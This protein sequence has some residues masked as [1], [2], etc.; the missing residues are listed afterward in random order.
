MK[1]ILVLLI[2]LMLVVTAGLAMAK[3]GKDKCATIKDGTITYGR[4]GNPSTE[5]LLIGFDEWGYNYQGRFF[6]GYYC[7]SYRDA[8]W[9]QPYKDIKLMMKWSDEWLSNKDCNGDGKLDRGYSC[10]PE[11]ASS[12]AC[13]GAWLTN[14]QFWS[15]E[16]E[17]GKT[18]KWNYFVKIVMVPKD[19]Y[20]EGDMWYT[21]D[22]TKI[23]EV[24]WGAYAIIQ[25]VE[26]DPCAGLHGL[27]YL[28][29]ASAGLGYYK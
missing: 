23:G 25:Q 19:A 27:Q 18:C 5:I 10:N 11:S 16:G 29:P 15:Y 12:S 20:K 28:S 14:H 26:N 21:A 24:I 2:G 4:V 13:Q 1:K 8:A 6:N 3:G 17:D 22:G 9:C 7:D